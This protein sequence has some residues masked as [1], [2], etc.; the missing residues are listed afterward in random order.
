[1][2]EVAGKIGTDHAAPL[3]AVVKPGDGAKRVVEEALAG[4]GGIIRKD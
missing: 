4:L 2:N 3:G 1:M